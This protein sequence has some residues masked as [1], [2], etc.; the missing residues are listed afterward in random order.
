MQTL[1]GCKYQSQLL[2]KVAH[3]VELNNVSYLSRRDKSVYEANYLYGY[4]DV[5]T[6]FIR[7]LDILTLSL[8]SSY[9]HC[10]LNLT[11]RS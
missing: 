9:Y 3:K 10:L 6:S 5:G 11:F 1:S 2:W 7:E 8:F 4:C